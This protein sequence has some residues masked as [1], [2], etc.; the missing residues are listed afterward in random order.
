MDHYQLLG[1]SQDA[2]KEEITKAYYQLALKHHPDKNKNSNTEERFKI[3][4]EAYEILRDKKKRDA[5]DRFDL[6]QIRKLVYCN[7]KSYLDSTLHEK[8]SIRDC[9]KQNGF[10]SYDCRCSGMFILSYDNLRTSSNPQ[11]AFI[12]DCDSCSSSIKIVIE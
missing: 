6:A 10:Y 2:S 12:I 3:L 5:Y 9:V 11:S 8:V 1:V 7:D 4:N